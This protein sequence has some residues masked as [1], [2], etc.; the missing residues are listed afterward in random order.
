[1]VI[2][3][4]RR[5]SILRESELMISSSIH[6][7]RLSVQFGKLRTTLSAC[8]ENN[9]NKGESMVQMILNSKSLRHQKTF[10][11]QITLPTCKAWG[12]VL[13]TDH[14]MLHSGR[15][16]SRLYKT[17]TFVR[18]AACAMRQSWRKANCR[19]HLNVRNE[20]QLKISRRN[21]GHLRS[22]STTTESVCPNVTRMINGVVS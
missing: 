5:V 11:K 8:A 20:N 16:S 6:R 3:A 21:E 4:G 17:P 15:P 13:G 7:P 9:M 1:M 14:D 18:K 10:S 2:Q 19:T 12:E 22:M